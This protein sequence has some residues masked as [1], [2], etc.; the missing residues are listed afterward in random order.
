MHLL[1]RRYVAGAV[2]GAI[3]F[4]PNVCSHIKGDRTKLASQFSALDTY[5]KLA[6]DYLIK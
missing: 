5:S 1:L 2:E 3:A 6:Q 4:I